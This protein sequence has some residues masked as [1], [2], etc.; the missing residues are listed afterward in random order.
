MHSFHPSTTLLRPL[1]PSF[2]NNPDADSSLE[3][4][5]IHFVAFDQAMAC[6]ASSSTFETIS[7]ASSNPPQPTRTLSTRPNAPPINSCSL[8]LQFSTPHHHQ[9]LLLLLLSERRQSISRSPGER[10]LLLSRPLPLSARLMYLY[11][12]LVQRTDSIDLLVTGTASVSSRSSFPSRSPSFLF[13][14]HFCLRPALSLLTHEH[15]LYLSFLSLSLSFSL[16]LLNS[17]GHWSIKHHLKSIAMEEG[18]L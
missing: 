9:H 7:S 5:P 1:A 11:C 2:P 3:A 15:P 10:N 14:S 4:S 13:L 18:I 8:F 16:S 17:S 6:H 12:L